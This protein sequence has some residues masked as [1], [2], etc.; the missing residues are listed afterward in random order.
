LTVTFLAVAIFTLHLH[1]QADNERAGSSSATD[2][3][4][5]LI[6][7]ALFTRREFFGAQALVPYPTA[8]ARNRLA[9]VQAKYG[10]DPQVSL[11]L[12]QLDE[13]L[14]REEQAL[15]EM[16]AYVEQ[17]PDQI[18]ALEMLASFAHRR[19]RFEMEAEALER[20]LQSAPPERRVE[21]FRRLIELART[22]G[23]EKY[24]APAFYQQTLAQNPSAVEIIEQYIERLVDERS[25][26]EALQVLR[27]YKEAFPRARAFLIE[28]EASILD[29]MGKAR[30]AEAVYTEGFDPF[31]PVELSRNFYQFLIDHDRLR[32]YGQELRERFRL[33][34]ADFDVAVKL[35]HYSRSIHERSP[36]VFVRLEKAR[37]A[38]KISW[39]PDELV[40]IT[41]LLIAD[42][43]ADAASRFLYT[44]YLQGELK[45]GSPLRAR[46]LYQL[47]ELLSDAGDERLS[48]TRGDLKFY[49]DIARADTHP[50]ILGGILSLILS[51]T[52]PQWELETE[53]RRA[54]EHFNRATAYRIFIAYKQEYPTSPE[55]AQMYL[56]IVRLYTATQ[57]TG[58]AAET[59]AEFEQRYQD[60]PQYP[61]VALK[62]ADCYIATGHHEE[63]RNLYGRILDYLGQHRRAGVPLVPDSQQPQNVPVSDEQLQALDVGAE[64]TSV[65]P[66][67]IA[68]PPPSSPGIE[69]P[70]ETKR[71]YSS[72]D[73]LDTKYADYLAAP[74]SDATSSGRRPLRGS[75]NQVSAVDYSTVLARYVASLAREERT[76]DVL[77]LYAGEIKKYGDEQGLYE[78]MLQWLGQTN[79]VEDQL[80]VYR[81]TIKKFPTA[82]W[83]DRLA[84]WFLRQERKEEFEAFSREVLSKLDDEEVESYL[85]RFVASGA[86]GNPASFDANLYLGLYGL[87]HERFP[88]HLS[89]VFGLLKFYSA[90]N[91]WDEWR[92]LV[93]EY[94]FE[95]REMRDQFLSHLA[96]QGRLR[97]YLDRAREACNQGATGD[98]AALE[99]N[100]PYELF[101]ADAAAWLS[102]YEE[103]IDAYR[104]LD[105]LY[106]N[107]PQFCERLI[108]FTRSLGQH[109]RRFLEE[110]ATASHAQA[111]AFPASPEYRTR[112]GEIQAELGDYARARSEW[113]QLIALG[114]GEPRTYLDTATV[115][116]DYFQYDDALRTIKSLRA[117]TRD[118]TLYALQA[119]AILE[120]RHQLPDALAEY[121]TALRDDSNDYQRVSE[122]ARASRRLV[123]L[124]N[125]PGVWEQ[126][127]LAF[128]R[129][130]KLRGNHTGL[131]LNYVDF[132]QDAK[133]RETASQLLREEAAH[134]DSQYFLR[135]A[136][137]IFA[138]NKD[139]S[140]EV[141]ALRRLIEVVRAPRFAISYRLQLTE[142]YEHQGQRDRAAAVLGELVEKFPTNYGVL[143]ETADFYR[144]IGLHERAR[145]VLRAGMQRGLGRFHYLFGRRL[146]ANELEQ[147]RV[148]DAER[149]LKEL[150]DED[151]GN[152]EVFHELAK[153]YVRTGNREALRETWRTTLAAVKSQEL[154]IK[155]LRA[156]VAELREQMI[157]AFTR[158]KDF[159]SAV[160]QHIE[161]INRDPED[162]EKLEAAISYVKRYG[163]GETL[164]DYYQR[165][166]ETAYKNYRWNVV[167]AR[168]YEAKN[169]LA[170]AARQYRAAIENQPEMLELYDALASI[171]TRAGDTVAALATLNKA[172]ELSNDDPQYVKRL[173][174][175]LERAGRQR[176]AEL[177]RRRLPVE[178]PQRRSVADQFAEAARLR[179]GDR[180][181]A[182][183]TYRQ[184]FDGFVADPLKHDLKPSDIAGYVQTVRAEEP[185]DR[186]MLRL[187]EVRARLISEADR[188]PGK[189]ADRGR[190]VVRVLD[191]AIPEALGGVAAQWGSGDE[192]SALYSFLEAQTVA[193]LREGGDQSETLALLQNTASRAGFGSLEEKIL[194]GRKDAA[195]ASGEPYTFH[196][197][198]QALVDF[199]HARAAYGRIVELLEA[200]RA[201]DNARDQF[202]YSRL[203]A[204]H[205]RLV[206]DG[207]RERQALREN[208]RQSN[209]NPQS[210][211][212]TVEP[213]VE[214]YFEALYEQ[215]EAGRNELLTCAQHPTSHQLQLAG[216]LLRK[217]ERELAHEAIE[218]TPLPV[219]WKL[220]R[221]AEASLA[222]GEFD[223]RSEAYF[224]SA[225]QFQPVGELILQKPDTS[226]QLVGDDWF[227]LAHTYG[228]WLYS[229]EGREQRLRSRS[230]LPALVENRPQDVKEQARLGRWLLER[231]DAE[232]ALAHLQLAHE[233]EPG[234][235]RTV[236]D[237]GSAFFLLGD[238]SRAQELWEQIVSGEPSP[239][240]CN[241]YLSTLAEH[242]LA[243]EARKRLTPLLAKRLDESFREAD[244]DYPNGRDHDVEEMNDLLRALAVSFVD[245]QGAGAQALSPAAE[246]ARA[247]FFRKLCEA[248]PDN[249]FLPEFLLRESLVARG[250]AGTFYRLLAERSPGLESYERDYE[251]EAQAAKSWENEGIEEALDQENDYQPAEPE[252]KRIKWQREYLA[253]LIEQHQEEDARRLIASIE[254]DI[255][256]RYARPAWLRLA[257]C[258]L[259]IRDGRIARAYD[260]LAHFVG[261]E[262]SAKWTAIKPP[263]M[264]RL[265][266]A[267]ALLR[268]EGREAEALA[269]IEGSYARQIALEQY[270]PAYFVGLASIAFKRG[271][272]AQGLLWLQS[273]VNLTTEELKAETEAALAALPLVKARV[274]EDVGAELPQP[275]NAIEQAKALRLASEA[276][277]EFGQL[278]AAL[279]FRQQLSIV[280]PEDEENR[281]ELVRLLAANRR[282]G[283]A[284]ESLAAIIADRTATR[285]LRWQAVWLAP[286]ITEQRAERWASLRERAS[287]LNPTDSE[288]AVALSALSLSSAGRTDEALKLAVAA[289]SADPNP[290]LTLF[291][292][293]LEKRQGRDADALKGFQRSLLAGLDAAAWRSFG[294]SE[295]EPLE[296]IIRLYL[297]GNQPRAALQAAERLV[298]LQ[299]KASR[300]ETLAAVEQSVET[301]RR[302][303][304]GEAYQTL[305]ARAERRR[306][307]SLMELLELLS[308]AAERSGDL[309][310]A[311]EME[312]ARL[313]L[314]ATGSDPREAQSRLERLLEERRK[315]ASQPQPSLKLDQR[316]VAEAE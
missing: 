181:R 161:I 56:D 236:A 13:K 283:E 213:L 247:A 211:S 102:N 208:Y 114:R 245:H 74:G 192:L 136:R 4:S 137:D 215:G 157:E 201:R 95:S 200:E 151:P 275:S 57:E 183:A 80:R 75:I 47:F 52:D 292:A 142:A 72:D 150:H 60:A 271:E 88:H 266:D 119:G 311:V 243:E 155:E 246:A 234:D 188:A 85:S 190:A 309:D 186:I 153:L 224:L 286:E 207:E 204:E 241:L 189:P 65:K 167:L 295:D 158:L 164:L 289:E 21:I 22:H 278:D 108:S 276:A 120:A 238:Q 83:R 144:R 282:T 194:T 44:L 253:Y 53:E 29:A 17:E 130:R 115:Y 284:I 227:R 280:S 33:E 70:D 101:R 303:R 257:A 219:A 68:Y 112:A 93:A 40:T 296:Q 78:Q 173:V 77:A 308:V 19:A 195:Y 3:K 54:V 300:D 205:A 140:G 34:P 221:N 125:R 11:K 121:M 273:M 49:E 182:I 15:A 242:G 218:N 138:G 48:L 231:K 16:R 310:R 104:K 8:E 18:R 5:A 314:T 228:Q 269:L 174:E 110:A 141:I 159:P 6:E 305:G 132:L 67:L 149:V 133:R 199:Y 220:S 156:Q 185:L 10:S 294:F 250:E 187:W 263:S 131:I 135:S 198:L 212:T 35:I 281:I 28:T 268:S 248:A 264:E 55:L 98:G 147:N 1:A 58:V 258:R 240:A 176:E 71:Y 113:E 229:S 9:E 91:R 116:W 217:G 105:R 32:A 254:S 262:T 45:P 127:V 51:D 76:T 235:N 117:R 223:A 209:I 285:S 222:L 107:T 100:L 152:A 316:L 73:Y 255:S 94:Y 306:R 129:E 166:S 299:S 193:T 81:E 42:G 226:K 20:M 154:D 313:A 239:A 168:I 203:I 25:Y 90:H 170:S 274:P 249:L 163:G 291:H 23:L 206:G 216:F 237:L 89:F 277:G 134:S 97:G 14:G 301:H 270:E 302:E 169:D 265:T 202:E 63:E 64:P 251:Y 307:S 79:M 7:S 232:S 43:Y 146:A 139:A 171:E 111:D 123:T 214:R 290:Y 244:E 26:Q 38:R 196:N 260:R 59:L 126:I 175:L 106:P 230:F 293:L 128:N 118:E 172:A 62:L 279:A 287:S 82:T 31:W 233:A 177:A 165:T 312:K 297:K 259:E 267:A 86:Y 103:A 191:A 225:L 197:R 272:T 36:E 24:L 92:T 37:A 143:S 61:E 124:S 298:V 99:A 148:A 210:P 304:E 27:Q 39:K 96:G 12:S 179:S 109:N 69:A 256:R 288:M 160:E 145:G 178:V 315:S 184:A 180:E 261:V 30:E 162:E 87:A 46:V 50:G 2:E 66:S 122:T 41:R 252:S 84:R